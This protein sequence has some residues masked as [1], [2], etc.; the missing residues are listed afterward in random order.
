MCL[1]VCFLLFRADQF[2]AHTYRHLQIKPYKCTGCEKQF[3]DLSNLKKHE[4][5]HKSGGSVK[6]E[7]EDK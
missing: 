3:S 1:M 5:V 6:K 7:A 2:K 4:K